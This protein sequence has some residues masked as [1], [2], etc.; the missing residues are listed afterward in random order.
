MRRALIAF[1]SIFLA[2]CWYGNSLY[3]PSDAKPVVRPGI[4]RATAEGETDRV[5]RV[6]M[7]SNGMTQFDGGEKKEIYGFAPLSSGSGTYV[8]WIPMKDEDKAASNEPGEFQLYLLMVRLRDGEYRVYA[9]ECKEAAAEIARKAGAAI[10]AGTSPACRF[11][12]RAQ[13]EKAPALLP[14][15]ES[16]AWRLVRIP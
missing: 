16:S 12:T 1:A 7:L 3:T 11:D 5:Y 8:L 13:L 14:R 9:P 2:G 4:Y 15:D 10:E 6:S